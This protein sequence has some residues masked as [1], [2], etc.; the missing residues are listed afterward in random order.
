MR[1]GKPI[2]SLDIFEADSP[3]LPM[4]IVYVPRSNAFERDANTIHAAE[5]ASA[6]AALLHDFTYLVPADLKSLLSQS[7]IRYERAFA[8]YYGFSGR[9]PIKRILNGFNHKDVTS[10]GS[11]RRRFYRRSVGW[12]KRHRAD[13]VFTRACGLVPQCIDAGL[14]VLFEQHEHPDSKEFQ[15]I[16]HCVGSDRFLG[17]VTISER[18]KRGY[19]QRL[20]IPE[21][22]VFVFPDAINRERLTRK[23]STKSEVRQALGI[24][25]QGYVAVY[26]GSLFV[27]KG[28]DTLLQAADLAP[29]VHFIVVGNRPV[30][31]IDEW[32]RK[33]P[34]LRNVEFRGH[35]ANGD[36]P[37]FLD[38]ADCCILPNSLEH[39]SAEY[40]SP[41][42]LFEY[43]AARRP[44]VATGIP[45]LREVLVSGE[46][47]VL[48]PPDNPEQLANAIRGLA[49]APE[50]ASRISERAFQ[51]VSQ[52][53]WGMRAAEIVE[54][55][56]LD[57]NKKLGS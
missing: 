1:R 43:M 5:M 22:S 25:H 20:G 7:Q 4:K 16:E 27:H 32:Q 6:L 18:L 30:G 3:R 29:E 8:K 42:K 15:E 26:A 17:I 49:A 12:L 41:L 52:L 21:R 44:V 33:Y 19:V 56:G 10:K 54:Y 57:A 37:K 36:I 35:H 53:T 11:Y 38:A 39:P 24:S 55:F 28:I 13:I 48:V 9:V 47:A 31:S 40:T 50:H 23:A 45:A 14:N 46:N 34:D 51:D 2:S